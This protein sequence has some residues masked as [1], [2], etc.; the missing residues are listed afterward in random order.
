MPFDHQPPEVPSSAA[1]ASPMGAVPVDDALPRTAAGRFSAPGSVALDA[2]PETPAFVPKAEAA[3]VLAGQLDGAIAAL[4]ASGWTPS[5]DGPPPPVAAIRSSPGAGKSRVARERLAWSAPSGGDVVWHAPTLAL[6]EEAAEHAR[7]LG[8]EAH[9]FRGRSA[10]DPATGEPMC[11]K[12]ALAERVA[13]LSLPVGATLC[14]R[15]L[16]DGTVATCDRYAGCLYQLQRAELPA[17]NVQRYMATSH[18]TLPDPTQ[19]PIALRV[20]DETFW[21][22]LVRAVD[23]PLDAFTAPR[24]HFTHPRREPRRSRVAGHHVDLVRAAGEVARLLVEGGD[25]GELPYTAEEMESFAAREMRA[26]PPDPGIRPDQSADVQTAALAGA[27]RLRRTAYRLRRLWL[28]LA[29]ARRQGRGRSERVEI[30]ARSDGGRLI[31]LHEREALPR[32]APMLL[33]DAD[34][35]PVILDAVAPGAQVEGVALRP[36]AHVI[37][38]EDRR[39][40]NHA[41]LTQPG[42]RRAWRDVIRREVLLDR[43]GPRGGVL[44]G[45]TRKVVRAFFEDAGHAFAGTTEAE[46]SRLMLETPLHGARWTWFGG[47]SL[48]SNR[49]RDFSSVVVIGREELPVEALEAHARALFG[50][51]PGEALALVVPDEAGRRLLPEAVVPYLMADGSARGARVRLHPDP[52]VRAVQRQTRELATRQL[53]ERLRLAHAPYRKR[54]ILGSSV[55]IPDLPVDRLVRWEELCPCR[56]EAAGAEALLTKGAIRLSAAGLHA[57]A[58]GTFPSPEA[59]KCFLKRNPDLRAWRPSRAW[60]SLVRADVRPARRGARAVPA[61]ILAPDAA[62]AREVATRAFG[63]LATFEP[64]SA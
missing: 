34:V 10:T 20:I 43:A 51:A 6:V 42:L 41:L 4:T 39:M 47:R 32:D 61:L 40:S 53:V 44:V 45:A 29:E 38:L 57:D 59:A 35:D 8:A 48:G 64:R 31:R 2:A 46:V 17:E 14:R 36:N 58:P 16:D 50:D 5:D 54:V 63:P 18:V 7:S 15:K 1:M 60:P 11:A 3:R 22:A 25:M 28:V 30:V 9:V 26:L 27:E 62:A 56:M 37:Q 55:P 52:R 13:R 21:T 33:L 19:R 23:V 24:I 12:H 49:Y